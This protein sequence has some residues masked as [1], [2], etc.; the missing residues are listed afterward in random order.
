MGKIE[1]EHI[2]LKMVSVANKISLH[3]GG[4]FCIVQCEI[5]K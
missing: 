1:A 2:D 4:F 3:V 5:S